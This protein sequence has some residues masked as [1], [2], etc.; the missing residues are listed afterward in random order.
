MPTPKKILLDAR[1]LEHPTPLQHA[2]KHLQN[3]KE[4]EYLYMI[5]RKKPIPLIEIAIEKEFIYLAYQN[6]DET[7]HILIAKEKSLNLKSLLH[8]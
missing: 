4:D 8:V 6:K 1:E 5:H 3:M 7:W 2:L